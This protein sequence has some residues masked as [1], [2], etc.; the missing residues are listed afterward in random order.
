LSPER[1]GRPRP[2]PPEGQPFPQADPESIAVARPWLGAAHSWLASIPSGE[3]GQRGA[4]VLSRCGLRIFRNG[5]LGRSYDWAV[6]ITE[7]QPLSDQDR[8]DMARRIAVYAPHKNPG[9][10][11]ILCIP[12]IATQ[13]KRTHL[14][15]FSPALIAW[16]Y[17]QPGAVERGRPVPHHQISQLSLACH[18][19]NGL[20][21]YEEPW[22]MHP[23]SIADLEAAAGGYV[24]L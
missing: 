20:T 5:L 21:R 9:A 15:R 12:E 22:F 7:F 6:L 19:Q 11:A 17:H 3:L 1:A 4:H 16:F 18:H 14:P 23:C 8:V 2:E 10:P 24:E 13:I